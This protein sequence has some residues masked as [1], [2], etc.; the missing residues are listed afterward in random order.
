MHN[1]NPR[2]F[3]WILATLAVGVGVLY[4]LVAHGS[5]S[6]PTFCWGLLSTLATVIFVF[7][8]VFTKWLWK[9]PLLQGWLVPFP[10]LNGVWEGRIL[11]T[12]VAPGATGPMPPIPALLVIKQSFTSISC[13]MQTGEMKSHSFAAAFRISDDDQVRQIIYSYFSDPNLTVQ[14]RSPRH[15]GTAKLDIVDGRQPK[16]KGVYWSDRKTTGELEFTF[17]SIERTARHDRTISQHPMS[18]LQPAAT[19]NVPSPPN[20][21]ATPSRN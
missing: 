21:H 17:K 16:L 6:D 2:I 15:H 11:S 13:V 12:W 7:A 10:N 3:A 19:P 20:P 14:G 8:I 9:W 18:Q 1:L 5:F 4:S